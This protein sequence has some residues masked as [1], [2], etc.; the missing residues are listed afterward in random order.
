MQARA[1]SFTC[2]PPI[3]VSRI[4]RLLRSIYR[5]SDLYVLD[6]G[7]FCFV[8]EG[9]VR[10]G[11]GRGEKGRV[12]GDSQEI[13]KLGKMKTGTLSE[14]ALG[15]RSTRLCADMKKKQQVPVR[16]RLG[17]DVGPECRLVGWGLRASQPH[18]R[19]RCPT[20]PQTSRLL[21]MSH[22]DC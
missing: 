5:N 13:R 2:P 21:W 19:A 12:K 15:A 9:D 3:P 10:N 6:F 22:G 1:L 7:I 14:S 16:T 4:Q 17:F 8:W 18:F 11:R 20:H